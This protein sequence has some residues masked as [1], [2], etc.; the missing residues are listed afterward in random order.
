MI[1]SCD[2]V[3]WIQF[4]HDI[5][6]YVASYNKLEQLHMQVLLHV[7]KEYCYD[8]YIEQLVRA[9]TDIKWIQFPML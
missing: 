1:L 7:A 9:R 6:T 3:K 5:A 8:Q 4:P 2:Q